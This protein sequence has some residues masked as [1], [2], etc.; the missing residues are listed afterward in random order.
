MIKNVG[1]IKLYYEKIGQGQPLVF[2]HGNGEDHTTFN[3]LTKAISD[4]YTCYLI[5]SR[6]HGKSTR[7]CPLHYEDMASDIQS[8]LVDLKI[9][10]P[11]I[12][13]FS[14]GAITAMILAFKYPKLIDKL[15]LAGGSLDPLGVKK[16]FLKMMEME[17][18][19]TTNPFIELMLKEPHITKDELQKI[20]CPTLILAGENDVI[21]RSHTLKIHQYIRDSRMMIIQG[22]DHESY[23]MNSNY[24]KDIILNF[25]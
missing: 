15:I 7:N 4:H 5:D 23:I 10:N 18:L 22:H 13:G 19:K 6:N 20:N 2:L 16:N 8:F 12:F 25:A 9:K 1:G 3:S 11:I 14:D 24:L 17:Y 21:K